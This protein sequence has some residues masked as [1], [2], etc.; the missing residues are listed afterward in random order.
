[1]PQLDA[2][3]APLTI[4]AGRQFPF[5]SRHPWVHL[6]SLQDAGDALTCGGPV[7]IFSSDGRWIAGGLVN[8]QS[9]LRVR[10]YTWDKVNRIDALFLQRID[11]A[12]AD[13]GWESATGGRAQSD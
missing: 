9:R 12:I 8:P 5:V 10:L 6:S 4:K 11:D 1:M 3:P 7:E 2:S 13:V